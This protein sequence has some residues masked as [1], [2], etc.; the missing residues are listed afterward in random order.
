MN[1]LITGGASGLGRA[2]T[3]KLCQDSKNKVFLTYN[4]SFE[5]AKKL[6]SQFSNIES[7]KVDFNSKESIDLFIGK[8]PDLQLDILVNN[9]IAGYTNDYFHKF[10]T[11][12]FLESFMTNVVPVIQI[13]QQFIKESRK[14]KFGKIITILTSFI[15]NKPPLGLAEYVANKAYLHSLSK[16]WAIENAPFGITSNCVSPSIMITNLTKNNIDERLLEGMIN[17]NPNKR[18]LNESEVAEAVYYFA[19]VSGQINGANLIINAASDLI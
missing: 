12:H 18:L 1:I 14:K 13:T 7:F 16:S 9:A 6:E 17:N 2:I 11:D 15:I 5:E 19:N 4:S 8:M 3:L 10:N